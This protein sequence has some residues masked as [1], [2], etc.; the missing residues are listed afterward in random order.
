MFFGTGSVVEVSWLRRGVGG[1]I[2]R[3]L[4]CLYM[5][6]SFMVLVVVVGKGVLSYHSSGVVNAP[7][8]FSVNSP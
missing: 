4:L 3:H 1:F 5:P 7:L 6:K 2:A 8:C